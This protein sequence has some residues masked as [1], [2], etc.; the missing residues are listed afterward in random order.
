MRLSDGMSLA[1]SAHNNSYSSYG[2]TEPLSHVIATIYV[3]I[4]GD[5]G[6]NT[7]GKDFFSFYI[8]KYGRVPAGT[9][10]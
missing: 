4:N 6:P 9:P 3:D 1:F 2:D 7:V 8:T 10:D 5:K